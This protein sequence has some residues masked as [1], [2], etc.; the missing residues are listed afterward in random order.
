[1]EKINLDDITLVE[2]NN[3]VD[4]KEIV[5]PIK[6]EIIN[7]EEK[8]KIENAA[9]SMTEKTNNVIDTIKE[10][11]NKLDNDE[12]II[13]KGKVSEILGYDKSCI[14]KEI[15]R[16]SSKNLHECLEVYD[17]I[18]DKETD[19]ILTFINDDLLKEFKKAAKENHINL[20]NKDML[21]FFIEK[22]IREFG[23]D[24]LFAESKKMLDEKIKKEADKLSDSGMFEQ[25]V[26]ESKKSSISKIETVLKLLNEKYKI[27]NA[28]DKLKIEKEINKLKRILSYIEDVGEYKYFKDYIKSHSYILNTNKLYKKFNGN[29]RTIDQRFK[30]NGMS[31]FS[32]GYIIKAANALKINPV[33]IMLIAALISRMDLSDVACRSFVFFMILDLSAVG[34]AEKDNSFKLEK[35]KENKIKFKQLCKELVSQINDHEKKILTAKAKIKNNIMIKK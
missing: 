2:D 25:Y 19:D 30:Q 29:I 34:Y 33:A 7:E 18:F 31:K 24:V 12:D 10:D 26:I 8:Q 20:S 14:P 9:T 21:R 13:Y 4:Q 15:H 3:G 28:N 35:T 17:Q 6:E 5:K 1:M 27:A 23:L 22:N 32:F 16:F 11:L